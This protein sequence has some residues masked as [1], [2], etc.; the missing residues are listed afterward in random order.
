MTSRVVAPITRFSEIA[1]SLSDGEIGRRQPIL[2]TALFTCAPCKTHLLSHFSHLPPIL[3]FIHY[4]KEVCV[5]NAK[6]DL[7]GSERLKAGQ[8]EGKHIL[9]DLPNPTWSVFDV[10]H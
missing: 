8:I 6:T 5:R 4:R 7:R 2:A 3:L 1:K 9:E 10:S